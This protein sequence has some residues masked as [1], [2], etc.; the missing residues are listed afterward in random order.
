MLNAAGLVPP[1]AFLEFP[2]T[3][4]PWAGGVRR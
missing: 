3:A 1:R 2:S 4:A